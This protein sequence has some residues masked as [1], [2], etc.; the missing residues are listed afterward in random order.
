MPYYFS[1]SHAVFSEIDIMSVAL[2]LTI[3][4]YTYNGIPF[5]S[6]FFQPLLS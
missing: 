4:V 5:S 1:I 2:C 3:R 6:F